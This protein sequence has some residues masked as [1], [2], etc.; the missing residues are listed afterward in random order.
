MYDQLREHELKDFPFLYVPTKLEKMTPLEGLQRLI[1]LDRYAQKDTSLK[2]LKVGDLVLTTVK[3]DPKYPT[4]GYGVVT[5]I[6]GD[7]VTIDIQYPESVAGLE[8]SELHNLSRSIYEVQKPVEIYWEQIAYRVAKGISKVEEENVRNYWFKKFY[9]ML[10]NMYA[11]P[12]GRVLYGAGSNV[13]VTLFNCFVLPLIHDSRGGIIDHIKIAAEIMS[14]GGGVGSNISTL[15][16]YQAIVRGVNGFSSGSVSW[17][18]YL[19]QLT[20]MIS[21]AGS[22]RGA[23][24]IGL[25]DWHPDIIEFAI[26]K[27]QNPKL[28]EKLS[29]ESPDKRVREIADK[30]IKRD[31]NGNIVGVVDPEFMSGANISVL[32]SDDFMDA[33]AKD[34]MWELRFPDLENMSLEQ[35]DIYNKYWADSSKYTGDVRKWEKEGLPTKVYYKIKARDLWDLF[36]V[37]ARYS[38]EPG[39]IYLDRYNKESNSWYYSPIL[40]TNPCGE[41]GLPEYGVCNLLSINLVKM[42]DEQTNGINYQLLREIIH[43]SQRFSD[44]VIDASFYFLKENEQMAKSERRIGKGVMGLADLMIK[45]KLRYGS[46]EMLEKTDEIFKIIATESYLASSDIAQEKG[47]FSYFDAEKLLESGYMKRMPEYVREAV[48]TKGLRN[49]ASLTVAPTGSTGTMVGIAQGLEPYF[50]FEMY[51]SGKLGKF[52]KINVPIAQ[53]YFNNNPDATK[54]PD[55]F[56]GAMDLTPSQ[57]VEV[58]A[59]IQK[60]VDSSISKTANAPANFTVKDTKE[61][62][63]Q[64]HALGC[65][66]VTIYV[67]GSRDTQVLSLKAEENEKKKDVELSISYTD[68]ELEGDSRT[69]EIRWEN[70]VLIKECGTE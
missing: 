28:L 16:P 12:G 11:V 23:Q 35:K 50:A 57:H 5:N 15:R 36:M 40:V 39:V 62:Y 69:C 19:S 2:T 20:H 70:G 32:I 27:I 38:A 10:S 4:Q 37:S 1:M 31:F 41:Q 55:Y 48:R 29:L 64:A 30:Y 52:I 58:Q 42:F 43:V 33:V 14:R 6:K 56:V 63:E 61:L 13:D 24:M 66:G 3:Y 47:S 18:N 59:V 65:K 34:E 46:K 21:Q 51:R 17:G 60:W 53:E 26:C 45:L 9:W 44:D 68:K 7:D 25:A 67:D 8:E 22:R 49:V 54:L